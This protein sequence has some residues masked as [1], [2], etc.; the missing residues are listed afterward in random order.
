MNLTEGTIVVGRGYIAP[1]ML[2]PPK[3]W[4]QAGLALRKMV[5]SMTPVLF[6]TL[7]SALAL[8]N[9]PGYQGLQIVLGLFS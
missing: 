4:C 1:Q 9:V 2:I 8:S 3:Q 7:L 5:K 6:N